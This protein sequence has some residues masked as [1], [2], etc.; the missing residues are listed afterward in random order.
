MTGDNKIGGHAK[1]GKKG[2]GIPEQGEMAAD[3][4]AVYGKIHTEKTE[5]E[6]GQ[7]GPGRF[8]L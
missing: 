7:K 6:G 4:I 8:F 2:Q 5:E 1:G 3:N